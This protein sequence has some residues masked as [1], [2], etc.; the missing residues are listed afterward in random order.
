MCRNNT[1]YDFLGII[2]FQTTRVKAKLGK[3][4]A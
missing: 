2:L 3:Y 4:Y 1:S